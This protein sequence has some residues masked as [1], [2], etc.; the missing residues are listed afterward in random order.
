[1]R[2]TVWPKSITELPHA[3]PWSKGVDADGLIAVCGLGGRPNGGPDDFAET[4]EEQSREV[5]LC[6]DEILVELGVARDRVFGLT[7][8][9]EQGGTVDEAAY[10]RRILA[11]F[12]PDRPPALCFVPCSHFAPPRM[13]IELDSWALRADAALA[14]GARTEHLPAGEGVRIGPLAVVGTT[15]APPDAARGSLAEEVRVAVEALRARLERLGSSLEGLAKLN[16]YF[17]A[18]PDSE[19]TRSR[20]YELADALL[21]IHGRARPALTLL[22]VSHL[23]PSGS[24]LSVAAWAATTTPPRAFVLPAASAGP[25]E[26]FPAAVEA[27]GLIFLSGQRAADAQGRVLHPADVRAQTRL[28]MERVRNVLAACG[29]PFEAILRINSHYAGPSGW[30]ALGPNLEERARFFPP[31][32]PMSPTVATGVPQRLLLLPGQAV[33]LECVAARA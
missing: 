18:D 9:Y 16:V 5:L 12:A 1:M 29:A 15:T 17:V 3:I 24:R 31:P 21:G 6:L 30:E 22:P 11:E 26:Q 23:G 20:A 28:A 14:S 8:F 25:T 32:P 4:L 19:T 27:G 2:R 10:R 7:L 33:E 13:R